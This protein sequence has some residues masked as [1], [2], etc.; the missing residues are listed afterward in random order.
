MKIQ[1]SVVSFPNRGPWGRSD[2]R[3]NTSGHVVYG[4]LE[5]W[6]RNREELFVDPAEGSG[7]SRDVAA[8]MSIRYAGF[9]LQQGFNLLKDDLLNVLGEE[10]ATCFFHPPYH[11]MITYSSH[12]DDLSQCKDVDEFLEKTLLATMNIYRALKRGGYYAILMGNMRKSGEFYPLA[13]MLELNCPGTLKEEII[14][15]QNNVTSMRGGKWSGANGF[16]PIMHEKLLVW[17]KSGYMMALDVA[18]VSG[19]NRVNMSN[20]TWRNLVAH[21]LRSRGK[22]A[23]LQE[24]YEA[25]EGTDKAKANPHWQEKVRQTVGQNPEFQRIAVGQYELKGV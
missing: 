2:F 7:T 13:S 21:T 1:N 11:T 15:V 5:R 16:V 10:A 17:Q 24:L 6:H 8:S 25:I 3:G 22:I 18:I 14:K 19:I 20:V 9:D 4:F 23:T 12:P